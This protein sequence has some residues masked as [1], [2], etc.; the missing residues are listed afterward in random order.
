MIKLCLAVVAI[1]DFQSTFLTETTQPFEST[2]LEM[3]F[4]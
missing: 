3:L 2:L 4:G 1:I